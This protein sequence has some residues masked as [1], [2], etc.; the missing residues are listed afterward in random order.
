MFLHFLH[1]MCLWCF[2]VWLGFGKFHDDH[3]INYF[4][5]LSHVTIFSMWKEMMMGGTT[6][7]GT[8]GACSTY[9]SM[10]A[11]WCAQ[12]FSDFHSL[13][14]QRSVVLIRASSNL[15]I[16][17]LCVRPPQKMLKTCTLASKQNQAGQKPNGP[18]GPWNKAAAIIFLNERQQ[19]H[20]GKTG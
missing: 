16:I 15:C 7:V 12:C 5:Y 3:C 4:A 11:S 2:F 18:N 1:C 17:S 10:S 6:M 14:W 8:H 19:Q 20:A 13:N 9:L